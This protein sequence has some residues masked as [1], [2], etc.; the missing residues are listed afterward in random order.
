MPTLKIAVYPGDGIGP[1]VTAEAVRVLQ[2]VAALEADLRLEL[3]TLPWGIEYWQTHGSVVPPDFLAQVRPFDAI[4]LGAVGWPALLPDHET[5]SPLVQIRQ[6]F[7]QYA[8]MRPAKLYRGLKSVLAGKGPDEI[9]F[10]VL[11]ENSEGEYV[12]NGGRMKRGTP[13]EF[14]VQTAVHTRKG[15]ERI[16]RYGFEM[17]RK[18]RKK[19]TMVTK[20]NAQRY[21]YVLW[22]EV[23][24]E[25][26]PQYSDI[27]SERQHCDACAMNFVRWPEK[28]DVVVASNL[29]GDLLTDLG[30]VLAGGLGL[31]PSTNTNPEKK[32][33]SMFEPVHGSAPD[34]AGRGIANP[35]AAVLSTAMLLDHVDQPTAAQRVRTAVE[36]TLLQ[37]SA[38]PDLGGK[39][40]TQQMGEAVLKNIR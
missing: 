16:L 20:S 25:L 21:A 31:A 39:L 11:R 6:A 15:V 18:R 17:A 14:A 1:E 30:G 38:T 34:I 23:L 26:A 3:T 13:D 19:L 35:I 27:Q 22:D 7:D 37:G 5:L 24:E 28:F 9:D 33:P 4:L 12:D 32:F 8:C 40:T 36:Q 2:A 10:V 29:F